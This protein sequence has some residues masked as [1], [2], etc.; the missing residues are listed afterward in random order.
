MSII[1]GLKNHAVTM[2]EVGKL[3]DESLD[4]F[5]AELDKVGHWSVKDITWLSHINPC[6]RLVQQCMGRPQWILH[7]MLISTP[8]NTCIF[9]I[10]TIYIYMYIYVHVHSHIRVLC[11]SF[12]DIVRS[13]THDHYWFIHAC[14][15]LVLLTV[16]PFVSQ[17]QPFGT[18][19]DTTIKLH[20]TW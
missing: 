15:I 2:F 8:T 4:S 5:L 13:I 6:R 9:I 3:T 16:L 20:H 17:V 14:S 19:L 12:Y 11:R 7:P 18:Y 10:I 1:Q